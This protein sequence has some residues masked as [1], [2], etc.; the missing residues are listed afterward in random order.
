MDNRTQMRTEPTIEGERPLEEPVPL[1]MREKV[2][3]F[4]PRGEQ[5]A[6][7]PQ[8]AE[9]RDWAA[10]IDLVK[11]A[12][13]AVRFAEERAE[14]AETYSRQLAAF[15]K[16]QIKA[17]EQRIAAAERRADAALQ[18]ANEAESW[19]NRFHDAIVQGFGRGNA[20]AEPAQEQTS[21][22]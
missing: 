13:E 14:T 7:A 4:Q 3:H 1:P 8:Q 17:A 11:E 12:S 18:R 21:A 2:F 10:A 15:H 16:E 19:L 6:E 5:V 20:E 22:G 9:R